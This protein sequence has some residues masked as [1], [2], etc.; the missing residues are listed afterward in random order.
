MNTFLFLLHGHNQEGLDFPFILR[1][2]V[3]FFFFGFRCLIAV[4]L[5]ADNRRD[6]KKHIFLFFRAVR[7]IYFFV[8]CGHNEDF[9]LFETAHTIFFV[10]VFY[11]RHL[12]GLLKAGHRNETK[13][14]F[15]FFHEASECEDFSFYG[16]DDDYF[17][18]FYSRWRSMLI[19]SSFALSF[20]VL[21]PIASA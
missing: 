7:T 10:V 1:R 13:Q 3:F 19:L 16:R 21:I 15:P 20:G 14:I 12:I 9:P 17:F 18:P 5:K 2:L 6:E 4:L 11:R 8:F